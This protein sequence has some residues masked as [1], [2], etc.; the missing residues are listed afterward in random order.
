M[1]DQNLPPGRP[2]PEERKLEMRQ[3]LLAAI[4]AEEGRRRRTPSWLVPGVAAAAVLGIVI[5]GAAVIGAEPGRT[6]SQPAGAPG[7]TAEAAEPDPATD[8]T[9]PRDESLTVRREGEF[10][11]I[12]RVQPD[13]TTTTEARPVVEGESGEDPGAGEE[14]TGSES[15]DAEVA[16]LARSRAELE[17]AAVTAERGFG[18]STTLLYE[19]KTAWVVC[20]D[21]AAE[22]GG[23]PTLWNYHERSDAY[24]PS[25]QTLAISTNLLAGSGPETAQYVA[26]G[27][28]FDGVE[29]IAYD[30]PD[31]HVEQAVVGRNGLWSMTYLTEEPLSTT[32]PVHVTVD[33]TEAGGGGSETFTLQWGTDTCAQLNHGC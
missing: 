27:R 17:G 22:D 4:E 6:T 9:E 10:W 30:F 26:A 13:G 24:A 31:G 8:P 28:D 12:E 21:W 1:S 3:E 33:Y 23:P 20:D 5:A 25:P 29:A 18:A 7:S 32:Q 14:L 2:L 19:T 16:S 15:C 11:V